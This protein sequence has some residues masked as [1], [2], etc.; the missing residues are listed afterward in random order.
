MRLSAV[1]ALLLSAGVSGCVGLR[2]DGSFRTAARDWTSLGGGPGHANNSSADIRAPFRLMWEYN[3]QGGIVAQPLVRD[4]VV[5][6]ATLHGEVQAIDLRTGK[7]LGYESV[8]GPVS[9]TPSLVGTSAV[10]PVS[11]TNASLISLDVRSS[12]RVW[13]AVL[14]PIESSPLVAGSRVF[15]STVEGRIV[16]LERETGEEL[17]RF[18]P[19]SDRDRKPMRSS[20]ALAGRL[21]ICGSDDGILYALDSATGIQQWSRAMTASIFSSPV[22]AG[23]LVVAGDIKGT[24]MCCDA[25]TGQVRWK[26]DSHEPVY[27]SAAHDDD[28]FIVSTSGGTIMAV[29]TGTG[30]VRWRVRAPSVVNAAP[31]VCGDFV[32]FGSLDRHVRGL[33]RRTGAEMW[34]IPLAGRVKVSPVVWG[35]ILLLTYEDKTVAAYQSAKGGT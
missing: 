5:L 8:G 4:S 14:G 25:F 33:D 18:S 2:L 23:A 29:D 24:V 34:S 17:W 22:V 28:R 10:I 11:S 13:S 30:A 26:I 9:G 32:V 31:L 19:R 27:A 12:R 16:C 7:R 15:V 35:D 3:A 1:C 20:P 6:V 21:V